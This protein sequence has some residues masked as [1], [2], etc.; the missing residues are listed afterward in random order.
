MKIL[1]VD[2]DPLTL[3]ILREA[4]SR[5]P[6]YVVETAVNGVEALCR[7]LMGDIDLVIRDWMMPEMNGA[8]LCR[9]IRKAETERYV[10]VILITGYGGANNAVEALGSGADEF[11]TKPLDPLEMIA[12]VRSIQRL[13]ELHD[14]VRGQNDRLKTIQRFKDDWINMAVHDLRSPMSAISGYA[15]MAA[16][17]ASPLLG[18]W[19]SIVQ[20]ETMRINRM[21]EQMLVIAKSED[22][23]LELAAS[24]QAKAKGIR[25]VV[26]SKP[27]ELVAEIDRSLFRRVLDNLL[28]NALRFGP[29]GSTVVVE[30]KRDEKG[31][32]LAVADSGPG[33]QPEARYRIFDRYA[34]VHD[35]GSGKSCHGMGLAYCHAVVTAHGGHI[36]CLSNQPSGTR[37]E[38]RLP[39]TIGR[40]S[41]RGS[42]FDSVVAPP[43]EVCD[44]VANPGVFP[45][46]F[47]E[48]AVVSLVEAKIV[49]EPSKDGA[50]PN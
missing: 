17:M 21:L 5:E 18:N 3:E 43:P 29:P 37:I 19:L 28:G 45:V 40:T 13:K 8:D 9:N 16:T 30:M 25:L 46:D 11:L 24:P 4:L 42:L 26:R 44:A 15:E 47:D 49:L 10:Y 34:T 39:V 35:R 22:G 33:V 31:I 1:I 14:E 48:A 50:L 38:V 32:G 27:G 41:R 6:G 36:E 12:R 20:R 23:V 2:D 7:T